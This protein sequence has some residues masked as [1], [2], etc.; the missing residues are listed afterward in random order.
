[1]KNNTEAIKNVLTRGVNEVIHRK[2][3][4]S[5]LAGKKKLRV[6]LGFDPTS[7]YLHIGNAVALLK[8]RALQDLGHKAVIIVGDYT[9]MIGDTSD[10]ESERP[11]LTEKQIKE[12]IKTYF[13]Q[14]LKV[15]DPKKTE[16][17]YNSTWLKK[18]GFGEIGAMADLFSVNEFISRELIKKRINAGTRVGLR[19][20]L[21]PLMQGYDS[22]AIKADIEIGA[23]DQRFNMLAGRTLQEHFKQ[24]P[25]DIIM[26][27]LLEGTDGRKMS[28]SWG[29]TINLLDSPDDMFAKAMSVPDELIEKYFLMATLVPENEIKT[30]LK[31]NKNPRDQKLSLAESIVAIYHNKKMAE[32]AKQKFI[33]QFSKKEL[34]TDIP[35]TKVKVGKY[36]LV[37][38]LVQLKMV[39]SKSEARRLIEQ[40]GVKINQEKVTSPSIEIQK[41]NDLLLQVGKRKFLKIA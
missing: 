4:E 7:P 29:N 26:M 20:L 1:M 6:K 14:V 18:L 10:K 15:L 40:G 17:H 37:D 2:N 32:Q 19:E 24:T 23:T 25:Q 13:K 16:T 34:P 41:T 22:V 12:N 30:I 9:G 38:L 3:L 31:N 8:V 33:S 28:K 39:E 35:T 36:Q 27:N 11:M 5:N 21:Y